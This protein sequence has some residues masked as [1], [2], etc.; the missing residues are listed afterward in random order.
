[1]AIDEGFEVSLTKPGRV[2]QRDTDQWL[3]GQ[4]RESKKLQDIESAVQLVKHVTLGHLSIKKFTRGQKDDF[5]C[6]RVRT[7]EAL[8]IG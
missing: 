2:L 1:M 5:V 8:A 7:C 3:F 4:I 6:G